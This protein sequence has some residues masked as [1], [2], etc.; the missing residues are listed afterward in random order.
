MITA[1]MKQQV[2]DKVSALVKIA[3]NRYNNFMLLP[4]IYFDCVGTR[5]GYQKRNEL[6]FNPE[7]LVQNFERY[8]NTTVPHETA[9]YVQWIVF[10]NSLNNG[11]RRQIHGREWKSIMY[12]FGIKNPERCHSYDIT[13]VKRRVFK[14]TPVYCS[15]SVHEVTNHVINK[16][17]Q[18]KSFSCLKCK[19]KISLTNPLTSMTESVSYSI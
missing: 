14:R 5:G 6:H 4:T 10:P 16:L 2:F 7:L 15:C 3:S 11:V 12:L 17:Q 1:E 8:L 9:H 19:S 18:G 13:N